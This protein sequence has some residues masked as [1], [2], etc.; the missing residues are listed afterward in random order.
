MCIFN[1]E[2]LNGWLSGDESFQG[3]CFEFIFGSVAANVVMKN[4]CSVLI[5]YDTRI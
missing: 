1:D 3:F 2:D 5:I 4:F